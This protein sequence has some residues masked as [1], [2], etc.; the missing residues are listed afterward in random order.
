M[1]KPAE[2]NSRIESMLM[3]AES[4]ID[5]SPAYIFRIGWEIGVLEPTDDLTENRQELYERIF[6][7]AF[8]QGKMN[9]LSEELFA[10]YYDS[11][12]RM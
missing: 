5:V 8:L 3:I 10:Y 6:T 9:D 12:R 4:L 1:S 11:G 7:N 2:R